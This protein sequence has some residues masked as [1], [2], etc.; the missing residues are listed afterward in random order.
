MTAKPGPSADA[1]RAAD[2][3]ARSARG[4]TE[5]LDVGTVGRLIVESV[6]SFFEVTSAGLRL[7]EPDGVLV[8]IAR[9]STDG[10]YMPVG[11]RY[12]PGAGIY[13]AVVESGQP[14]RH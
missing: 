8:L 2:A 9:T 4:L 7:R 14:F 12:P 1:R 5:T 6:S 3:L 10:P 11:H 13:Q